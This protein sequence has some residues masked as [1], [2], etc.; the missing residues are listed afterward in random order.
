MHIHETCVPAVEETGGE[1]E[2]S[3]LIATDD[4]GVRDELKRLLEG[5]GFRVHVA[6]GGE[7]AFWLARTQRPD[8]I[9][10]GYR[11]PDVSGPDLCRAMRHDP[12][13]GHG[14]PILIAL[15]ADADAT[16]R[17]E[18]LRA[19]AWDVVTRPIDPEE[20]LA[21]LDTYVQAKR[22]GDRAWAEGLLDAATTLY[23]SQGLT[24]RARELAAMAYRQR[25]PLACLAFAP[26]VEESS[27][28]ADAFARATDQVVR[29]LRA[30]TRQ[31]D[32][33]GRLG[34]SEFA[35]VAPDTLAE[36]AAGCARRLAA[37]VSSTQ[38]P[39]SVPAPPRFRICV[40][41]DAVNNL[42]DAAF[43]VDELLS[44]ASL[45]LRWAESSPAGQWLRRFT[46]GSQ[47]NE[48]NK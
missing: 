34:S 8:A 46:P 41:Y 27:P 19:T 45:A 16:Q 9:L 31:S 24:R 4:A 39:D 43:G 11:L 15:P 26:K 14:T 42:R 32:V 35:L 37:A 7:E 48:V 36:G 47:T 33:V 1:R 13:L 10:L 17:R 40:G 6:R 23:N 5:Q 20:L 22:H 38:P 21:R 3:V 44:R 18:A 30:A 28:P 12:H 25:A 29:V 2:A